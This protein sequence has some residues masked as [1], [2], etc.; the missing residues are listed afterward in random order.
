MVDVLEAALLPVPHDLPDQL[1]LVDRL[2]GGLVQSGEVYR[3]GAAALLL[4]LGEIGWRRDDRL[5]K[6]PTLTGLLDL[7]EVGLELDELRRHVFV[8]VGSLHSY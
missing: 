5:L 1:A 2:F 6:A 4:L 3:L 8:S 7:A